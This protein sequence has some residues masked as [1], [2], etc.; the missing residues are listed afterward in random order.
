M[1]G[2]GILGDMFDF[3]GNGKLDMFEEATELKFLHDMYEDS[4]K[5]KKDWDNW[6]DNDDDDSDS[7]DSDWF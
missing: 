4:H 7:D 3:D 2:P 1:I 5:E 6:D